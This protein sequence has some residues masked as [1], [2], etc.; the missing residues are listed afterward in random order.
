MAKE[1]L[2]QLLLPSNLMALLVLVGL[3]C[4]VFRKARRHAGWL[5]CAAGLLFLVFANGPVSHYLVRQLEDRYPAFSAD[6]HPR[7][8]KEIVVLTGHALADPRLPISSTVNAASAFRILEALRL[9]QLFPGARITISGCEDVPMLMQGLLTSLGVKGGGIAI[10]NQ[11]RNTFESAVHLKDRMKDRD[12]ILVT[13][14]GH[15]PRSMAA[16]R[17]MGMNPT[18][19]PTDYLAK[20]TPFETN[21]LPN[22][23]N[24]MRADLALHEYF[25]LMWYWISGRL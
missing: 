22:S 14:A 23:H 10:E 4:L 17:Q 21:Y 5:F 16:F 25:G 2:K 13:S 1:I 19:A 24:L 3:C 18:P 6:R 11:S 15:M 7:D 9:H 8:F 12:F 20:M